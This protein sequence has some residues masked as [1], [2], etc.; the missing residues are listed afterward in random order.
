MLSAVTLVTCKDELTLIAI[1]GFLEK[2]VIAS[3]V[4]AKYVL[5]SLVP[6]DGLALILFRSVSPNI[7][8]MTSE[9]D[10]FSTTA[11]KGT[12]VAGSLESSSINCVKSRELASTTSEN[13]SCR[14]PVFRSKVNDVNSGLVA[15]CTIAAARLAPEIGTG[16]SSLPFVSST[17]KGCNSM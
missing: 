16:N 7:T 4:I 8:S 9:S 5:F 13:E 10:T 1:T 3:E 14:I 17:V 11:V 12:F 6:M 2:S 15:S